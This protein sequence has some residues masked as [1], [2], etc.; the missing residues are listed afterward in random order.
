MEYH[1]STYTITSHLA[2]TIKNI[3][4]NHRSLKYWSS[5]NRDIS[6]VLIDMSVFQHAAKNIPIWKQW[7]MSEW[8][9]CMCGV[10]K[11]KER[12]NGWNHSKCPSWLTDNVTVEHIIH[13]PHQDAA[14]CWS[15][16]LEGTKEW[17]LRQHSDPGLALDI[18]DRLLHWRNREELHPIQRLR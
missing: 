7:W 5:H 1:N 18:S 2:K 12:W 14:L 16:G 11:W 4:P 8:S 13:W 10:G 6:N 3:T 9:C 15:T 17:M